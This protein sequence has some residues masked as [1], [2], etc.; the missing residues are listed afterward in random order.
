[1]TATVVVT[2]AGGPAQAGQTAAQGAHGAGV[3]MRVEGFDTRVATANG[4]RIEKR[5][6]GVAYAVWVGDKRT[7]AAGAET[8]TGAAVD[9]GVCGTAY[10]HAHSSAGK[11]AVTTGFAVSKNA[12]QYTW[13]AVVLAP[14]TQ[15]AR[16]WVGGLWFALDWHASQTWSAP[17]RGPYVARLAHGHNVA[18]L[19]NGAR[20]VAADD[21]EAA[22]V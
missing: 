14:R 2:L 6:D 7:R 11:L 12:V 18:V 22:S 17:G 10:V 21:N 9:G 16:T 20:C 4:Y 3:P 1:M 5:N 19:V 8:P 13:R 15:M